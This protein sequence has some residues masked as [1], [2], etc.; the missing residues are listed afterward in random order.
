MIYLTNAHS[1]MIQN[2][3][4]MLEKSAKSKLIFWEIWSWFILKWNKIQVTWLFFFEK[5]APDFSGP[6]RNENHQ[7]HER[8]GADFFKKKIMWLEFC[9]TAREIR[10]TILRKSSSSSLEL[11][12]F[13]AV[14][15]R[16]LDLVQEETQY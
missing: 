9:A 14:K 10:T 8:S 5:S 11:S 13:F 7:H 15:I 6:Q 4:N 16:I 2:A 1:F 3:E 12:A